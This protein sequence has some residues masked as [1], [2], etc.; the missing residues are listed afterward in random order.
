MSSSRRR[1]AAERRPPP[2]EGVRLQK[3]LAAAGIVSRRGAEELIA[4]G[5][6]RVDGRLVTRLGTRVD[7]E[8]AR[9]E[10]DG[11]R[12]GVASGDEY[13][14]LNKPAGVVSTARDPQGRR[15]VVSLVPAEGR[16]YPVGR[17]DA[18][19]QGLILLTNH[20]ELA[21][22]LTHPR[23][24][25]PRTYVADVDGVVTRETLERLRRGVRLEDGV[26][27]PV[28]VAVLRTGR[29]RTQLEVVMTEGRK[30]EVRRMLASVGHPVR[31]LVRT[32]FGPIALGTLRSGR[33][34]RLTADEVGSLLSSVGL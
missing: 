6:V 28:S 15:T 7:P 9:I 31:G 29:D 33:A 12:V 30:R 3:V 16:V 27:R 17:L 19:T 10:V 2:D 32:S 24:Q 18:D 8:T 23:F 20:G 11:R 25:I 1:G 14:A 13:F 4:A 22:R 21:H 34:R 26:A 5:R